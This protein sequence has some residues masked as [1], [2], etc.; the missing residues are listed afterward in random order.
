MK[1]YF[2]VCANFALSHGKP[3]LESL[4]LHSTSLYFPYLVSSNSS[5]LSH[6]RYFHTV[7]EADYYIKY[8]FSR[9]PNSKASYPVLDASQLSLF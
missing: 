4:S 8:L 1:T 2:Q 6:S 9:Y 5:L 3:S 7:S